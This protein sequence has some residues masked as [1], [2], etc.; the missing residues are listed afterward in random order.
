MV[1]ASAAGV[2][3]P[4]RMRWSNVPVP[5]AHVAAVIAGAGL[6]YLVPIRLPLDGGARWPLA[7]SLVAGGVGLAAWAVVSAGE[8]DVERESALVTHGAYALTRNP[9]YVGWS[10]GVLGVA[11]ASRSVW[12]LAGW[13]VAVAAVDREIQAEESRLEDRFGAAYTAYRD[14]VPRYVTW[15]Q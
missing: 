7:T 2:S 8:A 12:M 9:M 6:H 5:E 13:A 4:N 15:R 3:T 14:R 10:A 11:L 1:L